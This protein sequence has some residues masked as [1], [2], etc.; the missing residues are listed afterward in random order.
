MGIEKVRHALNR[1]LLL[2]VDGRIKRDVE[3]HFYL[4]NVGAILIPA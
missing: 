3:T 4:P 2:G 1:G